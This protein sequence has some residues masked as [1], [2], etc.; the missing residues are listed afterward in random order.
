MTEQEIQDLLNYFQLSIYNDELDILQDEFD[1][2]QEIIKRNKRAREMDDAKYLY[3]KGKMSEE[4]YEDLIQKHW[5]ALTNAMRLRDERKES[6]NMLQLVEPSYEYVDGYREAYQETVKMVELG[7]VK[8]HNNVFTNPDE[9]DVVDYYLKS[10]DPKYLPAHYVPSYAYFAVDNGKFIGVVHIRVR[11]TDYLKRYGG[12]IG[13]GIHPK[14][15]MQG[16]GKKLLELALE[17]YKDL[18]EED[19]ILI[20][21]DDDNIGSYKIIEANGGVLDSKVPNSDQGEDFLTRRYY[22]KK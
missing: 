1:E 2:L 14:Y 21:C 3:F 17:K 10:R 16:Y 8:K 7:K 9:K 15:W 4:E 19:S 22:I 20:T 13:Y 6:G 11:L 18:I 5:N 12:H